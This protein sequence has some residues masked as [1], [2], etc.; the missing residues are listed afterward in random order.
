MDT[1][2]YALRRK[3][4]IQRKER[5]AL[6]S[7]V[8]L[9]KNPARDLV[10]LARDV[11]VPWK[12]VAD[13]KLSCFQ[14]SHRNASPPVSPRRILAEK[15]CRQV[16]TT[17]AYA[18]IR[19]AT[20]YLFEPIQLSLVQLSKKQDNTWQK[21]NYLR[22]WRASRYSLIRFISARVSE[23]NLTSWVPS[24]RVNWAFFSSFPRTA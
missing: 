21:S 8:K 19:G 3:Y 11:F 4:F 5:R 7:E 1:K 2:R 23:A 22:S 17:T 10:L 24:A 15:F 14:S 9:C 6:S 12:P 13:S 18:C 16:I 20:E